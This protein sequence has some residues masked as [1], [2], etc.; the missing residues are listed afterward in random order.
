VSSESENEVESEEEESTLYPLDGKYVDEADKHRCGV[1]DLTQYFFL[2]L[3]H[4]LYRLMQMH[5][6]EREKIL[7]ERMEEHQRIV[8]KRNLDQMLKDQTKGGDPE[9]VS[10]AAKRLLCFVPL[11]LT[12]V[13][14]APLC[15]STCCP[16]CYER[17]VPQ[18]RRTQG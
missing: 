16:R 13:Y 14:P 2:Y 15:R 1:G 12:I 18:A 6:I 11:S 17:K 5:E 9:N 4:P 3:N 7:G 10:K 8:D